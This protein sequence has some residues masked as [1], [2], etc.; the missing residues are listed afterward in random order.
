MCCFGHNNFVFWVWGFDIF[1]ICLLS[2]VNRSI[3]AH[4]HR[5]FSDKGDLQTDLEK[6]FLLQKR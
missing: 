1:S 3:V 6:D 5:E 4:F 2:F